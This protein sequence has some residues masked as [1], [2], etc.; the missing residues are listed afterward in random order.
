MTNDDALALFMFFAV[1]IGG[2][3]GYYLEGRNNERN[4]GE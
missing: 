4:N 1:L 2:A 3:I